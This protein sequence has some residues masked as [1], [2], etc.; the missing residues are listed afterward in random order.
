MW[1]TVLV[2]RSRVRVIAA[3]RSASVTPAQT[4]KKPGG[5]RGSDWL[6]GDEV[7]RL[8]N[9]VTFAPQ[10][11]DRSGRQVQP[12]GYFH[13]FGRTAKTLGE[14]QKI[15]FGAMED[16]VERDIGDLERRVTPEPRGV[17]IEVCVKI[18]QRDDALVEILARPEAPPARDQL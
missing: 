1:Q 17:P 12:V 18:D 6:S 5:G 4:G 2:Q 11:P 14:R 16:R 9:P 13:P 7:E 15:A 3:T 8:V 10:P